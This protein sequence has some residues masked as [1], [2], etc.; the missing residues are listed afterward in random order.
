MKWVEVVERAVVRAA[1]PDAGV[2]G[3]PAGWAG[4]TRLVRA[5]PVFAPVVGTG[6]RTWPGSPAIGRSAASAALR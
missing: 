5:V 4:R 1:A 6:S 3:D 2:V